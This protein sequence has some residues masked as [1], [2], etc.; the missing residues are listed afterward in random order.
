M[1]IDHTRR[2]RIRS[3]LLV[4]S[5]LLLFL[6]GLFLLFAPALAS[7]GQSRRRPESFRALRVRVDNGT[8]IAIAEF[9]AG[10]YLWSG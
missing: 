6:A 1:N 5:A 3:V 8:A 7:N 2:Q 10:G 9:I 4:F